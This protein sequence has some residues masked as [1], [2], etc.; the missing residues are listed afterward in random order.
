MFAF[1]FCVRAPVSSLLAFTCV[2]EIRSNRT[3][4]KLTR[5]QEAY[6]VLPDM[7]ITKLARAVKKKRLGNVRLTVSS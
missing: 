3:P 1:K 5:K 4:P 7:S 2:R 6:K